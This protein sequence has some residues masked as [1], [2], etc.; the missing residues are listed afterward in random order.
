MTDLILCFCAPFACVVLLSIHARLREIVKAEDEDTTVSPAQRMAA[1]RIIEASESG[2]DGREALNLILDRMEG[3][4]HQS[5]SL[6]GSLDRDPARELAE[7]G[8]RRIRE[9][10]AN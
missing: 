9:A 6:D 7:D 8:L 1:Q 2:R 4:P 5:V 3:K 10:T